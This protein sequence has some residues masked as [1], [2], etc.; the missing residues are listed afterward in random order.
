MRKISTLAAIAAVSLGTSICSAYAQ[1]TA[2]TIPP[3]YG[4]T[5]M[6]ISPDGHIRTMK[7]TDPNM[8]S[9]MS[10]MMMKDGQTMSA[11]VLLMVGSDGK[12][13]MMKDAMMKDGKMMSQHMTH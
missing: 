13:H 6:M 11:P 12:V 1:P 7:I 3:L 10:D 4:D 5:I 2:G 8:K 9:M